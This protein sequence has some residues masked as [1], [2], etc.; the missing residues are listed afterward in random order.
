MNRKF[1]LQP[2]VRQPTKRH[3]QDEEETKRERQKQI[4]SMAC[5]GPALQCVN[6]V[7][8]VLVLCVHV[9]E[10]D[11]GERDGAFLVKDAIQ[12]AFESE[13]SGFMVDLCNAFLVSLASSEGGAWEEGR[14]V[15]KQLEADVRGRLG[16]SK[17]TVEK[18][19]A[20]SLFSSF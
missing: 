4:T 3:P 6:L 17:H 8:R 13:G 1:I 19:L 9:Y 20:S 10:L 16:K 7:L 12:L 2:S 11:T 18:L 15:A 5:A 14:A